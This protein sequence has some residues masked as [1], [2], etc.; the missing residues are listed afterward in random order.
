MSK[1]LL[2][3]VDGSPAANA[4]LLEA[5]EM[6][7]PD[8]SELR[9]VH[10]IDE[11]SVP[12]TDSGIERRARTLDALAAAGE[13]VLANGLAMIRAAG[14]TAS[15]ARLRRERIADTVSALIASEAKSW[16]ADMIVIGSLGR[17]P[18]RRI[19]HC[20]VD[21]AV[22]RHSAVPVLPVKPRV[23]H[24]GQLVANRRPIEMA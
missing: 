10:V 19:L 18:L 14:L 20:S 11:T 2:I 17:G 16:G 23:P 3:A 7:R 9:L 8:G 15:C 1:R 21:A 6:A 13:Q 22:M 4:A 12:W 24:A 5:I